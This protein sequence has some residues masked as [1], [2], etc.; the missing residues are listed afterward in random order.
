MILG[1][2][3]GLFLCGCEVTEAVYLMVLILHRV[4][5]VCFFDTLFLRTS[6]SHVLY[7]GNHR[8]RSLG[9]FAGFLLSLGVD[10]HSI[11]PST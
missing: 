7:Y 4:G 10:E 2:P 1:I 3:V 11:V 5:S 8:V 6:V 9:V